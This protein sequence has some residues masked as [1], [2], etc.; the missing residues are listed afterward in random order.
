[1]PLAFEDV[2]IHHTAW[3]YVASMGGAPI[4]ISARIY[5]LDCEINSDSLL[6]YYR[7]A[8]TN[9]FA[10]VL[11]TSAGA[12]STYV[13]EIPCHPANTLLEYYIFAADELH[14][15]LTEPRG[16]PAEVH[17]PHV[18]TVYD[19]CE[20]ESGWTV[21]G[22]GDNATQGIWERVDPIGSVGG[23]VLAPESDATPY[24]GAECWITGQTIPGQAPRCDA[25]GQ[26]TL[27]SPVYDLSSYDWA[28]VQVHRWFQT[29]GSAEGYMV[30]DITVEGDT[31][32]RI[33]HI[34]GFQENPDWE[35][36]SADIAQHFPDLGQFQLRAIMF[37]F[38][39][40]YSIDEGG[41]DDLIIIAGTGSSEVSE[42]P[43]G[44][45]PT[46]QLMLAAQSPIHGGSQISFV[47]PQSGP[48]ALHVLDL[49]GRIVR[50]LADEPLAAGRHTRLWNGKDAGGR[51][52]G[53]GIYF[54]R[55]TTTQG[56]RSHR[57]L[58]AR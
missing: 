47:T 15:Q 46:I 25:D 4:D 9:E 35:M 51:V 37:G 21:G 33:D 39:Y 56:M 55:L 12:D 48:V 49:T 38:P 43:A 27:L 30:I 29:F 20:E 2:V 26:T 22:P 1:V 13:G 40:P 5:S 36:V 18:V 34:D 8:G 31:W 42:E 32:V 19:P 57:V 41:L 14:H 52:V 11:M 45:E 17:C 50:T 24:P 23:I 53:T 10:S 16:A 3:P 44:F 6:V 54:L 58:I 7:A 28:T